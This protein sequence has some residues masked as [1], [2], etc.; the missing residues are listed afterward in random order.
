MWRKQPAFSKSFP[1]LKLIIPFADAA[2]D[3]PGSLFEIA[4]QSLEAI[5]RCVQKAVPRHIET[6]NT[7]STTSPS[8]AD[9][10]LKYD[11]GL[12]GRSVG[13]HSLVTNGIHRTVNHVSIVS[14]DLVHSVA[15]GKIDRNAANLFSSLQPL[16]DA[17]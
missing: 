3:A 11:I 1:K 16:G 14:N 17:I 2:S 13:V 7:Q 12:L 5:T 10:V 9:H 4:D 15:F 8:N 6:S